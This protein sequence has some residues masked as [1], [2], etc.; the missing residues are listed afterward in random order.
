MGPTWS[1]F[2]SQGPQASSPRSLK[3]SN[4]L[5]RFSGVWGPQRAPCSSLELATS[6]KLHSIRF[7][8]QIITLCK[9]QVLQTGFR[10]HR[11]GC[12]SQ[13]WIKDLFEQQSSRVFLDSLRDTPACTFHEALIC[14]KIGY[15]HSIPWN[16]PQLE[17][18]QFLQEPIYDFSAGD[19]AHTCPYHIIIRHYICPFYSRKSVW[20]PDLWWW[21]IPLNISFLMVL[22]HG[23]PP[24]I[25]HYPI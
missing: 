9:I 25:I 8:S 18:T 12:N 14:L 13:K 5:C 17:Y 21:Y 19:A 3:S 15:P 10:L 7:Q 16:V 22:Y 24:I 23:I 6:K 20:H 11:L 4:K 2:V 1:Y